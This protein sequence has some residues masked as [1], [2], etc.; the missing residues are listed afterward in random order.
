MKQDSVF[1]C[2]KFWKM[3]KSRVT[4]DWELIDNQ[5]RISKVLIIEY[6]KDS[7]LIYKG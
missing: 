3:F 7:I 6:D 2:P 4:T 1:I 5:G